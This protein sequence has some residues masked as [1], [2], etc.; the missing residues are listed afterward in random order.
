MLNRG[1]VHKTRLV[2]NNSHNKTAVEQL[3]NLSVQQ[4]IKNFHLGMTMSARKDHRSYAQ[5]VAGKCDS[6]HMSHNRV[7]LD[8]VKKYSNSP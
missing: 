2:I 1:H 3:S 8:T 4:C 5:V 7:H 6:S